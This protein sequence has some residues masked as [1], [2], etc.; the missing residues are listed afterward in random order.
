M[1]MID[2]GWVVYLKVVAMMARG[3]QGIEGRLK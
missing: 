1:E 2:Q 3:D